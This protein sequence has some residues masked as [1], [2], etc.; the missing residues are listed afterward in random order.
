MGADSARHSL[1]PSVPLLEITREGAKLAPLLWLLLYT[2]ETRR[3]GLRA[4]VKR[5]DLAV[6]GVHLHRVDWSFKNQ[7][8]Y[9]SCRSTDLSPYKCQRHV[10]RSNELFNCESGV[11][12]STKLPQI[13]CENWHDGTVSPR[14]IQHKLNHTTIIEV[15]NR[16]IL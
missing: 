11:T 3:H 10:S 5:F 14:P 9:H 1:V 6:W 12:N 13:R 15:E 2:E 4:E 16:C 8:Q 7:T